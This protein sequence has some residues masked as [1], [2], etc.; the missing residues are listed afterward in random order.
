MDNLSIYGPI[1]L[2]FIYYQLT[3]A[4]RC[5]FGCKLL[6]IYHTM[7]RKK[8]YEHNKLHLKKL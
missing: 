3:L 4:G 7:T 6:Y 1:F 2:I 5:K 8:K